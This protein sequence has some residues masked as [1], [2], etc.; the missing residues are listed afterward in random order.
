[1]YQRRPRNWRTICATP[2]VIDVDQFAPA[3]QLILFIAGSRN[4][5]A[6]NRWFDPCRDWFTNYRR[7]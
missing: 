5:G 3:S 7:S 2:L 1:M 6:M 4:V